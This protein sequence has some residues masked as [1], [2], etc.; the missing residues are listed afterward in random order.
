M[1]RTFGKSPE[2]KEREATHARQQQLI[3][4]ID[5]DYKT[6]LLQYKARHPSF[7]ETLTRLIDELNEFKSSYECD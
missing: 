4:F 2:Q 1:A 5:A 7:C 3:E 6:F